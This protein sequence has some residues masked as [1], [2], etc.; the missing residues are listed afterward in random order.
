[1]TEAPKS[2]FPEIRLLNRADDDSN[3]DETCRH[4]YSMA[5]QDCGLWKGA[6]DEPWI[7]RAIAP[8]LLRRSSSGD[9]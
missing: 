7:R 1:M 5:K 2:E 3:N 4:S 9:I 6:H 8:M